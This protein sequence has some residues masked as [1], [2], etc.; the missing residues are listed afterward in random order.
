MLASFLAALRLVVVTV[1][2]VVLGFVALV[3][4]VAQLAFPERAEGQ[5]VR[6]GGIVVGSR[7]IAQPFAGE[8]YVWPRP[9]AV[10]HA[11]DASGGSNLPPGDPLLRTRARERLARLGAGPERR[12]PAELLLASGSGLDPHLTLA[13]ARWQA[14]R[15]ARA[16][17]VTTGEVVALVERVA[18]EDG[19]WHQGLVNV[20]LLDLALDDAW[21]ARTR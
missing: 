2:A 6:R 8:R 5:L 10:A 4:A 1:L 19:T 16:R 9:S 17:G 3:L 14:A 7:L 13:G 18:R 11:A 21:P 12:A 15:V 20:L